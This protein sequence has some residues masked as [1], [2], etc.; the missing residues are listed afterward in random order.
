MNVYS[1]INSSMTLFTKYQV[2]VPDFTASI[3]LH[4]VDY[5]WYAIGTKLSIIQILF[6]LVFL[7]I[8]TA[9]LK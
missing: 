1:P 3:F 6:K 8:S 4:A 2:I 7:N 9:Y 5:M